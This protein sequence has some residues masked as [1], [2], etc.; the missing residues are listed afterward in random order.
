MQTNKPAVFLKFPLGFK[1]MIFH[2]S[3]DIS[4]S[5]IMMNSA[6]SLRFYFSLSCHDVSEFF[7][8]FDCITTKNEHSSILLRLKS[9]C[10]TPHSSTLSSCCLQE[11]WRHEACRPSQIETMSSKWTEKMCTCR[12]CWRNWTVCSSSVKQIMML[13]QV[14]H[15]IKF[16]HS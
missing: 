4:D 9:T 11:D 15:Q 12:A 10:L 2:F 1:W 13:L 6:P 16:A 5:S 3:R 14:A 8:H 7:C